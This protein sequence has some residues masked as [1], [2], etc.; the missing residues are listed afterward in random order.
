M[1]AKLIKSID[2]EEIQEAKYSSNENKLRFFTS[3]NYRR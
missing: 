1:N 3:N 2:I